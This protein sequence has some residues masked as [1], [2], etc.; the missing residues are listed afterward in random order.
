MDFRKKNLYI[1]NE[2]V[3][4]R[5][6]AG[7][8]GKNTKTSKALDMVWKDYWTGKDD[9]IAYVIM[10]D[11]NKRMTNVNSDVFNDFGSIPR[12][13]NNALGKLMELQQLDYSWL[14]K[15]GFYPDEV[16]SLVDEVLVQIDENY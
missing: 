5:E 9:S 12:S 16:K 14:S 11:C 3:Y 2:N 15:Y 1:F 10:G 13:G 7:I 6:V 8:S 4:H